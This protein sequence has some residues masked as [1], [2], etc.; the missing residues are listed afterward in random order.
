MLHIL[1]CVH[2]LVELAELVAGEDTGELL[3]LR[4]RMEVALPGEHGGRHTANRHIQSPACLTSR[5]IRATRRAFRDFAFPF[6]DPQS[7]GFSLH[8]SL[9]FASDLPFY[10]VIAANYAKLLSLC[11][12]SELSVAQRNRLNH[13][14]EKHYSQ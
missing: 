9:P 13:L 8:L 11:D 7:S 6:C 10:F 14:E 1:G 5:A 2:R 12:T 4:G 3:R